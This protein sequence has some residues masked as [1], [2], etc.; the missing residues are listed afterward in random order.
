ML[1]KQKIV[2]ILIVVLAIRPHVYM[3]GDS[4][5]WHIVD[6]L[7]VLVIVVSLAIYYKK[8]SGAQKLFPWWVAFPVCVVA[9]PL[10]FL[11][12]VE[13]SSGII[14]AIGNAL[15]WCVVILE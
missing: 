5:K 13:Y 7:V 1:Y 11:L 2:A 9:V 6:L 10:Y 12:S 15:K 8:I 3:F 14:D 4:D